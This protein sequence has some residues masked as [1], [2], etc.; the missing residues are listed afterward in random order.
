[1]RI[2]SK[3][4]TVFLNRYYLRRG[5]SPY[6]IN[7]YRKEMENAYKTFD[8]PKKEKK[9][10][11]ERGFNPWRIKQYGLT[12]ENYKDVISDRDYF[13][14]YPLNNQYRK[15]IDDKLTMKY[16][17]APFDRFLPRYFYHIMKDREIMPLMDCP[18]GFGANAEDLLRLIETKGVVAAKAAAGTYGIGFYKL[19]ANPETNTYLANGK[20]YQK[21][22]F[23]ALLKSLDNYIITEFVEMHPDIK[24]LN[25]YAV[26]TIRLTVINEHG[27]DP[28]L[29]FAFIRIGTKKSG[30]VD[31]VAQGGMVCKVD[32]ETGRY[33][34]GEVLKDH[35]FESVECHPDSGEKLEGI[36]PHWDLVKSE[37]IK[38]GKYCPQLK[39]LGYDIAITPDGFSI[40]EINSHHGLHKAYEYPAEVRD[41][42][43]RELDAKKKKYGIK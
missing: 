30:V 33:Y 9:W 13:Y 37:I 2:W 24:K 11:Y 26:N 14:L 23:V 34:D 18:E 20:A 5:Y 29:P 43:F 16:V 15:W 3:L 27:N 7:F 8:M 35:V 4:K 25:P 19:E 42:L 36:I 40:I 21:E 17:L 6:Y 31:N 22:D 32:V 41:F 10:A 12:E 1:M 38:I 28:I 39:W